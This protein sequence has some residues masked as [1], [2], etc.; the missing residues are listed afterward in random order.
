MDYPALA[1]ATVDFL[2]PYLVAAGGKLAQDSLGVAREKVFGWL[3]SK[4]TKPA[5][6]GA[7]EEAAQSPQDAGALE[8][9]QLQIRRALE[10]QEEFRKELLEHLPK[11]V[12][13]PGITQTANVTGNANVTIQS[14]GSGNINVQR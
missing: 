2:K 7:L 6:S 9:L 8:A 12:L 5:Q 4:F 1:Q 11:E 14:A 10:Q 13:P 3:K